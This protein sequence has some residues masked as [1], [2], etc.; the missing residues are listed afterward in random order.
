MARENCNT[1]NNK[2]KCKVAMWWLESDKFIGWFWRFKF[3]ADAV[4]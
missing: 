2:L 1:S 3:K 4:S